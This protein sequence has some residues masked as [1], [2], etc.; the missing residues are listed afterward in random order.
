MSAGVSFFNRLRSLT[1]SGF[2]TT[3]MGVEDI[4]YIGNAANQ[5]NGVPADVLKQYGLEDV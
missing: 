5:W 1:A 4:G 2:Y 3:K